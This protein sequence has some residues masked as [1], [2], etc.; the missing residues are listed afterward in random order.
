MKLEKK[1]LQTKEVGD[2][3]GTRKSGREM[4][5]VV[6]GGGALWCRMNPKFQFEMEI[7]RK[8]LYKE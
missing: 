6:G 4:A 1:S 3:I 5:S 2:S 8:S 7:H